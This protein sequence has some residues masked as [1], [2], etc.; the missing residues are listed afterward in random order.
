MVKSQIKLNSGTLNISI[1][2]GG[3][4]GFFAAIRHKELFPDHE[5]IIYEKT[6]KVLGKVKI[7]GGGRC[8]VTHACDSP[9]ELIQYYP[10]GGKELL[11]PFH[12]FDTSHTIAWFKNQGID[13]KTEADGRMFPTTDKSETIINCFLHLVQ[14]LGIQILF[15]HE[16]IDF[17]VS[18]DKFNLV[19]KHGHTQ[20]A[21]K[22]IITS[23]SGETSWNTLKKAGHAIVPPV[24]SLF[25]F[26]IDDHRLKEF[27]GTSWPLV[28]IN[29]V[30]TKFESTGP[31]LITHWG[32]SGPA[33]LKLSSFAAIELF[34]MDYDFLI[35][36]NFMHPYS[37]VDLT[38]LLKETRESSLNKLV[39][40]TPMQGFSTR[41]WQSWCISVFHIGQ[42][43]WQEL[44][45]KD[46]EQLAR[47]LTEATFK[48]KGKSTFK[49]EFVTAG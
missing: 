36:V 38:R 35:A 43:K 30:G 39:I 9:K 37:V 28:E 12:Q 32:L 20:V 3:A 16:L 49:E 15:N 25:T 10:R 4:A 45:V 31:L 46:I 19:F 40:N 13:L 22:L 47:H 11:G 26:N 34:E 48:V 44:S 5:V 24:P 2:G 29:I 14:T 7:S 27:P 21:D 1:I 42:K 41:V 23:G 17:S 6:S 8:N 33:I 18:E